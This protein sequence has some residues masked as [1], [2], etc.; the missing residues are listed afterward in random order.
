MY[1]CNEISHRRC[2]FE[3][4]PHIRHVAALVLTVQLHLRGSGSREIAARSMAT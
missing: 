4:V 3:S 1:D 2:I